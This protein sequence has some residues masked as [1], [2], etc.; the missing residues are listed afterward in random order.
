MMEAI[1]TLEE[2]NSENQAKQNELN[3]KYQTD[4]GLIEEELVELDKQLIEFEKQ[5]EGLCQATDPDLFN[6]YCFIK[7]HKG[8]QAIS[9]VILGVCQTCHIGL[10]PQKFIELQKG[11]SLLTC[12]NCQRIIYWGEDEN[13]QQED[14]E[15]ETR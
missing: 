10:P 15:Q 9:A 3:E 8:G 14:K 4:R 7:D 1:E 11:N 13:F 2:K 5:R 6:R 12:P